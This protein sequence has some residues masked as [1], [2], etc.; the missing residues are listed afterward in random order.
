VRW[1]LEA[2]RIY[3][4]S[5]SLRLT[6]TAQAVTIRHKNRYDQ[7]FREAI[8]NSWYVAVSGL[9]YSCPRENCNSPFHKL[10]HLRTPGTNT[11]QAAYKSYTLSG[12][13][14]PNLR[15]SWE[16]VLMLFICSALV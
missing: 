4:F 16:L 1:S 14:C 10:W 6:L 7:K 8:G 13:S 12:I 3:P 9:F 15:V 11:N 5:L 2:R